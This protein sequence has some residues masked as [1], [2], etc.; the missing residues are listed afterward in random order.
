MSPGVSVGEGEG[1]CIACYNAHAHDGCRSMLGAI[2]GSSIE[3][4][5]SGGGYF[6]MASAAAFCGFCAVCGSKCLG[7]NSTS[8]DVQARNVIDARSLSLDVVYA[9][10]GSDDP[11]EVLTI[12]GAEIAALKALSEE[13]F[14]EL[15]CLQESHEQARF[16]Q[17]TLGMLFR[18]FSHILSLVGIVKLVTGT[19]RVCSFVT[20]GRFEN[21]SQ[22][23][24]LVTTALSFVMVYVKLDV[25][26]G[27][28]SHLLGA[29]YVGEI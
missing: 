6:H 12:L 4:G 29:L 25:K 28:W 1:G 21:V 14:L 17:T 27:N 5:I 16:S 9:S 26:A 7:A 20:G 13:V 22:Q 23:A 2:D 8:N 3:D 11:G 15:V 19:W 24:D 18:Y 10:Y